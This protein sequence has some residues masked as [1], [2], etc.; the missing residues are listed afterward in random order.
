VE[1]PP[2]FGISGV[3][4]PTVPPFKLSDRHLD[5]E[6]LF[7][8][9]LQWID[10]V[11]YL[12]CSKQGISGADAE[13]FAAGVRLKLVEDDYAVLRKFR[14]DAEVKTYLASVVARF[15]ISYVREM[16]GAWRSSAAAERLGAPASD[17]ER[18]VLR[19]GY[20]VQQAGEFL[21]TSGRTTLSDT[22]L[23]R[24]L[25]NLPTRSPLRPEVP[26]P[27]VGLDAIAD[28]SR[29]DERVV[30]AE[31]DTRRAQVVEALGRALGELEV[32]DRL[33]ARLHFGEGHTIAEVAREMQLEQKPLYRRVERL[34]AR[35]RALLESAGV[36]QEDVRGLLSEPESP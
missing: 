12:A 7:L 29:T 19:E 26:Q 8:Q 34:R 3:R 35:L 30:S 31:S 20:T 27:E 2:R 5:P 13:D 36:R 4:R 6:A 25:A 24:L 28:G 17:L 21:R 14:G 15:L 33:I 11:A 18:L 9:H 1:R 32:E 10:R 23:A 22:E 16:K